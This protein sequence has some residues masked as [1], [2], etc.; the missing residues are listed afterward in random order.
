MPKQAIIKHST[1]GL[2]LG[3]LLVTQTACAQPGG[4][5]GE[6]RGPPPE[7]YEACADLATDDG[8]EMQGRRGETLQGSCIALAEDEGSLVC[9]P[10]D[11]PERKR[12]ADSADR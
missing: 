3:A 1:M 12:D 6:R 8:C 11:A 9:V 5:R 7:A 2:V 4:G 10:E